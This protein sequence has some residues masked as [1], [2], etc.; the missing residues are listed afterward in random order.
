MVLIAV[1]VVRQLL[2]ALRQRE[3]LLRLKCRQAAEVA[4]PWIGGGA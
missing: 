4:M 3:E 1:R 2:Q